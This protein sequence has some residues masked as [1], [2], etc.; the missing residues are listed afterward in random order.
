[1]DCIEKN[2]QP[3]KLV[4]RLFLASSKS[5]KD[6]AVQFAAKQQPCPQAMSHV[7]VVTSGPGLVNLTVPV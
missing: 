4:T 3:D 5:P 1:M 2:Q 6:A 7:D